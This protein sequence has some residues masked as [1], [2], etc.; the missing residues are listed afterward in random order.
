LHGEYDGEAREFDYRYF[1]SSQTEFELINAHEHG[2][3]KVGKIDENKFTIIGRTSYP[4]V[5]CKNVEDSVLINV[6]ARYIP[7]SELLVHE[8]LKVA[9]A[10]SGL[11]SVALVQKAEVDLSTY[12]RYE[13]GDFCE[14]TVNLEIF[15]RLAVAL[16]LD[17]YTLFDEFML[18]RDNSRK[19]V[20]DYMED[21]GFTIKKMA[22][23][24]GVSET[25]VKNW[26]KGKCSPRREV[27]ERVFKR[28]S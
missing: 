11:T 9:R 21:K 28:R 23:V 19:I 22:E 10:A 12:S 26:R 1:G 25:S 13:N 8:K 27:W 16:K 2:V 24:C 14:D 7:F 4:I 20:Q 15:K 18:F 17:E 3:Y 5:K 6:K